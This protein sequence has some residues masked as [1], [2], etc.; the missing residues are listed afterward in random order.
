MYWIQTTYL[1]ACSLILDAACWQAFTS[2]ESFLHRPPF[3]ELSSAL[4]QM[5]QA[6]PC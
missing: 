1:A 3:A 6:V 4:E 5:M 2:G